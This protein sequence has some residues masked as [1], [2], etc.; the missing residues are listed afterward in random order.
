[1]DSI[2]DLVKDHWMVV[3]GTL[4][5]LVGSAYV[6]FVRTMVFKDA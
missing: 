2:V 5:V 3:A 4:G 1:M 6:P